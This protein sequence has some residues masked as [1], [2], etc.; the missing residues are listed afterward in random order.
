MNAIRV[1]VMDHQE[2]L[3]M[4]P[5]LKDIEVKPPVD[6]LEIINVFV[7]QNSHMLE[8]DLTNEKDSEKQ[9][10]EKQEKEAQI[11]SY[12]EALTESAWQNLE[13][14]PNSQL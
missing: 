4:Y 10:L 11:D 2:V 6:A 12:I 1:I 7:T 9:V 8:T 14:I 3:T 13:K 5:V